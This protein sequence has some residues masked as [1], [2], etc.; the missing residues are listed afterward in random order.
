[1]RRSACL[2]AVIAVVAAVSPSFASI[3]A[4]Y[5]GRTS[6]K[7]AIS[8]AVR[9]KRVL[10]FSFSSRFR[11]SDHTSFVAHATYRAIKLRGKRFSARFTTRYRAVHTRITGTVSGRRATGTIKRRATFNGQRKLDPKGSLVCVS[12]TRWTARRR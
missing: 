6:D 3:A 9:A 8:F 1:M 7:H 12:S 5:A 4:R 11:C 2:A 10:G